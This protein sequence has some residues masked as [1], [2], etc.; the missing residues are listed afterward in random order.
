MD[1]SLE[2]AKTALSYFFASSRSTQLF[3]RESFSRGGKVREARMRGVSGEGCVLRSCEDSAELLLRFQLAPSFVQTIDFRLRV[4]ESRE[5]LLER[6]CVGGDA[7]IFRA[8]LRLGE[9]LF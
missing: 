7:W 3:R 4:G 5:S 1:V 2:A 8:L 9:V 6:V